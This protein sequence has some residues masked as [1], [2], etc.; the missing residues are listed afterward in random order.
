VLI[1]VSSESVGVPFPGET[2]APA[3]SDAG[4]T[5]H[6]FIPLVIAAAAGAI[7]GDNVGFWIGRAGGDRLPRR[8][9]R[10]RPAGSRVPCRMSARAVTT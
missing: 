2:M 10:S 5:H 9:G 8:D 6:L 7:T 3:A 1:V 4:T